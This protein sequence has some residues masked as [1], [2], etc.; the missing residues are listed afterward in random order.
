MSGMNMTKYVGLICQ[1]HKVFRQPPQHLVFYNMTHALLLH[2]DNLKICGILVVLGTAWVG[3]LLGHVPYGPSCHF[4]L[5]V[6]FFCTLGTQKQ[7]PL[8]ALNYEQSLMTLNPLYIYT[9]CKASSTT[10]TASDS[11]TRE[12]P[13]SMSLTQGSIFNLEK[14]QICNIVL[15]KPCLIQYIIM[16]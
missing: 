11:L 4:C 2:M 14:S 10:S 13:S 12:Q 7:L 8:L 1:N 9:Y 6:G 3:L 15:N 16:Y 5:F